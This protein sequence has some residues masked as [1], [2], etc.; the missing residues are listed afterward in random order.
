MDHGVVSDYGSDFTVEE[1]EIL[2]DLLQQAP[3]SPMTG[4]GLVLKDIDDNEGLRGARFPRT[5]NRRQYLSGSR[6]NPVQK[7]ATH[8]AVEVA[9]DAFAAANGK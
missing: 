8:F 5:Y 3:A 6:R 1:E 2:S 7:Q 9:V 4:V